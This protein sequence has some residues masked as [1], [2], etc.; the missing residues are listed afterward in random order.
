MTGAVT[1]TGPVT[2]PLCCPAPTIVH[3]LEPEVKLMGCL[4]RPSWSDLT[5]PHA[6]HY[7]FGASDMLWEHIK[8]GGYHGS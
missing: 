1:S 2:A 6:A 8:L 7:V 4:L 5:S 3:N